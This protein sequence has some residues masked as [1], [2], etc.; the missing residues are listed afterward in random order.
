MFTALHSAYEDM[1][2]FLCKFGPRKMRLYACACCR[3][4]YDRLQDA[5]SRVAV[6]V[7]ERFVHGLETPDKLEEAYALAHRVPGSELPGPA[8]AA[9]ECCHPDAYQAARRATLLHVCAPDLKADL[10]RE[11]LG[12]PFDPVV[13]PRENHKRCENCAGRGWRAN[14]TGHGPSFQSCTCD[15]GQVKYC[16]WLTPTVI[17][18][19]IEAYDNRER[20]C[21]RCRK[22][23]SGF[24]LHGGM[25][26]CPDC[27]GSGRIDDGRL[28][29]ERLLVLADALEEEGC[30][31]GVLLRHLRGQVLNAG[32]QWA[33][34]PVHHYRGC[35]ALDLLRGRE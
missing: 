25:P 1:P 33:Q 28:S 12:N 30:P 3:A 11:M 32:K 15:K 24:N 16:P 26:G 7:A 8:M 29:H 4:E 18:L 5:R 10:L 2:L 20:K 35:W 19:T 17:S 34:S 6:Y 21:P 9:A 22:L 27:G 14:T 13:L 31:D 23:K